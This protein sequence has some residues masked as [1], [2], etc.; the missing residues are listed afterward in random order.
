[1]FSKYKSREDSLNGN[2]VITVNY[3]EAQ[4]PQLSGFKLT[5]E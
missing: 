2:L 5:I 1:M 4:V 3:Y